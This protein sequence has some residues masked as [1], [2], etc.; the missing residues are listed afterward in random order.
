MIVEDD[1]VLREALGELM[2]T[3]GYEPALAKNGTDALAQ[4]ASGPLPALIVLD[5]MM[6]GMSGQEFRR[7]QL[8]DPRLA[9]I[10][11]IVV[12]A[13]HTA[14]RICAEL[15]AADCFSKP[16]DLDR[17]VTAVRAACG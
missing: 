4:L 6:P 17:L 1:D 7:A 16:I 8:A 2:E 5:L 13:S 14:R 9:T 12:S 3:E 11:V 10:P 15:G